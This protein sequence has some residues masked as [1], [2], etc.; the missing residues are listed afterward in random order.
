MQLWKWLSKK[1]VALF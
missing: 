1:L